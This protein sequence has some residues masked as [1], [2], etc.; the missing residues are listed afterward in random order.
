VVALA[1][2]VDE[3]SSGLARF[4]VEVPASEMV[5]VKGVVEASDGLATVF[6]EA[7]VPIPRSLPRAAHPPKASL[8]CVAAPRSRE[9][10]LVELLADLSRDVGAVVRRASDEARSEAST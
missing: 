6:A 10:E 8:L 5:F 7:H 4:A 9:A 2:S 1:L 3:A